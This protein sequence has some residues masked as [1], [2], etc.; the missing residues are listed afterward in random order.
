MSQDS[1]R[2]MYASRH[3]SSLRESQNIGYQALHQK[4]AR[5]K[6][7]ELRNELHS[8]PE[9]DGYARRSDTSDSPAQ[10]T[11]TTCRLLDTNRVILL[12]LM[13]E[14]AIPSQSSTRLP[15]QILAEEIHLRAP[16][17]E[18]PS[19]VVRHIHLRQPISALEEMQ[20]VFE[21]HSTSI[22]DITPTLEAVVR[23]KLKQV[24]SLGA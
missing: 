11:I 14:K 23:Q 21:S 16:V 3:N 10:C 7:S 5:S 9:R 2:N 8:H 18:V 1:L 12:R 19:P 15:V 24:K 22:E 20:K 4:P 6:A 13:L 17:W